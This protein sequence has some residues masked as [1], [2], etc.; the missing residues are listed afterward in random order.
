[1]KKFG[2]ISLLLVFISVSL[3]SAQQNEDKKAISAFEKRVALFEKFFSTR[4]KFLEKQSYSKSP[5]GYIYFWCLYD[6]A[7]V[8]YDV[9]KTDSL[10]SP[11]MGYI[12]V[13][14]DVFNTICGDVERHY[15]TIEA[16]RR[17]KDKD[18]CYSKEMSRGNKFVFAFQQGKWIFKDVLNTYSNKTD[19]SLGTLMGIG[20]GSRFSVEDNISWRVL[21]QD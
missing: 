12:T 9:R 6:N 21:S 1:M 16:A 4:P 7:H 14:Y 20:D 2:Y 3:V 5:S 18:S 11:Y 10:I 15:S 8:S 17:D 19:P 13:T